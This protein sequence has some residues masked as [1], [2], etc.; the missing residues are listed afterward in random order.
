MGCRRAVGAAGL[1]ESAPV[2]W[3]ALI[4]VVAATPL[5]RAAADP[6][7]AGGNREPANDLRVMAVAIFPVEGWA[8]V[9]G[10]GL[11]AAALLQV[12]VARDTAITARLGGVI[13]LPV[14]TAV[15]ADSRVL[16]L[17]FLGGARYEVAARPPVRGFLAG[18]VGVVVAR[19][20]VS[21]GGVSDHDAEVRFAASLGAGVELG[22]VEVCAAAW[23]ADLAD[24]D[25]AIGFTVSAGARVASW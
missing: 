4:A 19:T 14:T 12:P 9:A 20:D 17:P 21:A 16:E 5:A 25:H 8:E 23:L 6:S 15:G 2:R 18:E 7:Q 22:P 3:L 11:G 10:V 24:L 13:H 1:L